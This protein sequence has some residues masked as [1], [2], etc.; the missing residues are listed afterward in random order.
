V[1]AAPKKKAQK[2]S[3]NEFLGDTGLCWHSRLKMRFDDEISAL[4]S[5]A[6]EMESLP[7]ARKTVKL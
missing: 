6:D 5:W 7:N 1:G 4:G 3:L 2:I